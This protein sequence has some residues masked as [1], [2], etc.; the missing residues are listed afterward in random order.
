MAEYESEEN[1]KPDTED[2]MSEAREK[3]VQ[4]RDAIKDAAKNAKNDILFGVLGE[5]WEQS[6]VEERK[7]RGRPYL[8]INKF[9]AYIRQVVNDSRQN[10][11]R[12]RFR[13]V[14]DNADPQTAEVLN[15]LIRN[16]EVS[17]KADIAYDSAIFQSVSG[18]FGYLRVNLDYAYDDTFDQDIKIERIEN[19]FSVYPDPKAKSADGSDWNCCFITDRIT[20]K[21]FQK[22]YP[23]KQFTDFETEDA[24]HEWENDDGIWIAEYW[25]REEVEREICLLSD[26]SVVDED[27]YEENLELYEARG[28]AKLETR[29]TKSYKVTQYIISGAEILEENDWVGKY[30]PIVPVYGEE[31]WLEG[32]RSFKSLIR[33]SKDPQRMLNYWRSTSTELVGG[34]SKAPY[35]GEEGSFIDPEK[36]AASNVNNYSY[37]EYKKGAPPP[38]KQQFA[39]VPVGVI[40][41]GINASDDLQAT[42]GMF[43][44]S[45]GM[46]DNAVS[47]RAIN[48]RKIESDTGTFHFIDN[49]SRSLAHVGYIIL[50]LIPHVYQPGRIIRVLG[51]DMR[52]TQNVQLAQEGQQPD[53]A[54]IFDLTLGRYDVTVDVGP[55][56]TT[57]R[58]EAAEQMI[59]FARVNPQAAG[60]ISDLIAKNLDWPGAQEISDRFKAVLPPQITGEDPQIQQLQQMLQ[61]TQQQAQ[62][63]MQ[64][65][66]QQIEQLKTDKAIDAEK[67]KIDAYNAETN[68]LKT[69]QAGLTPEQVQMLVV[70]T[71]QQLMQ[72]PDILPPEQ[73]SPV[74][75]NP[76]VN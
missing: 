40:Q 50:D 21:E 54:N 70:Q 10:R 9:P 43:G 67:V 17:S 73:I 37:L 46:Q 1:E 6:D 61:Q 20:R 36:W 14:D 45:I 57:R 72:S 16:I 55:G 69:M 56:Y 75:A 52:E 8:T 39:G 28:I 15:G 7:R 53:Y 32:E 26:G 49:L 41:E 76:G 63:A 18:G 59:E 27:V 42:M 71:V 64:Q 5:Q 47:G 2:F 68:R 33:D 24:V 35:L 13:P 31:I 65:L 29:T 25:K 4:A 60:L 58:Q 34:T 11:P 30:I 62:Q 3:F 44:A 22:K 51:E 19:Q 66:Q 74:M 23:G 12:I 48:A 38:Q